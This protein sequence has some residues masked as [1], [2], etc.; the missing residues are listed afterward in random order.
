[1][2][3]VDILY[4]CITHYLSPTFIFAAVFPLLSHRQ[5]ARQLV[6]RANSKRG[7]LLTEMEDEQTSE[8]SN[9]RKRGIES[10]ERAMAARVTL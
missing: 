6:Y 7:N 4:K 3:N 10:W 9:R 2:K 5:S 8:K 1:M